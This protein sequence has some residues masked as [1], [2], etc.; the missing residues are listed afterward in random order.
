MKINACLSVHQFCP[1]CASYHIG[2][3]KLNASETPCIANSYVESFWSCYSWRRGNCWVRR[4]RC[5]V[6]KCIRRRFRWW[7]STYYC[8]FSSAT[9]IV[10]Y[11]WTFVHWICF[12]QWGW[13]VEANWWYIALNSTFYCRTWASTD[14][15]SSAVARKTFYLS[16]S[17]HFH[18]KVSQQKVPCLYKIWKPT[19][20][21]EERDDILLPTVSIPSGSLSR[22]LLQKVSRRRK[23]QDLDDWVC[24]NNYICYSI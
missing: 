12:I 5:F 10:Y 17:T 21:V 16:N 18:Q 24:E 22:R 15:R 9:I 14:W 11:L 7:V 20:P 2:A 1:I 4:R 13:R 6:I 3:T 23:L 19:G 8:I